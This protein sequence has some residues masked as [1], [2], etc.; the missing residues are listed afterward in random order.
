M[1]LTG[2]AAAGSAREGVIP[3]SKDDASIIEAAFSLGWKYGANG[4]A[5]LL[6]PSLRE[7][8]QEMHHM[9]QLKQLPA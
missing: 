8:R 7:F 2:V 5:E 4:A 3:S 9:M 6:L 1:T